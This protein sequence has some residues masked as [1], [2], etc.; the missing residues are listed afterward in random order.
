MR[1]G[2]AR[3]PAGRHQGADRAGRGPARVHR[4]VGR[5]APRP[6]QARHAH[7]RAGRRRRRDGLRK[8][9]AELFPTARHQR[10]C[11]H[12]ARNVTNCLP[13]SA[14]PGA[15]KAMQEIYNAEDRAH[16]EQAIEAF[17]KA[18]GAKWSRAVAKITDDAEELPAFYDFLPSTRSICGPRIRS[19]RR[20]QRSNSAPRSPAVPAAR[21]RPRDGV[22]GRRIRAGPLAG[23]HRNAPGA[24]GPGRREVR[25]WDPGQA[26][27]V[28]RVGGRMSHAS[29]IRHRN[30]GDQTWFLG[31]ATE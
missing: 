2:P 3:R 28:G 16:A 20:F 11:V 17:A 25:E 31:S 13:M 1:A 18:Y 10:C 22:Q 24:P 14:Q 12:K 9:P 15:T 21:R 5:P 4:V 6:P 29:R 27:G 8:A 30:K 26:P 23:D 19:S 7:P